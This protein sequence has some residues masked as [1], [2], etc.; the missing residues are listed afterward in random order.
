MRDGRASA[1]GCL[2]RATRPEFVEDYRAALVALGIIRDPRACA[3]AAK[4]ETPA[5]PLDRDFPPNTFGW[6]VRRYLA[7]S[8]EY[9]GMKPNGR[10]RRRTVL[11]AMLPTIGHKPMIIPRA[12]IS[13]G[14]T[15]RAEKPG[16]ANNWLKCVKALYTWA[17]KVAIITESPAK[18]LGK[19]DQHDKGFH[20]WSLAEIKGYIQRHPRGSMAYLALI[21]LLFTGLRRSDAITLGRQHVRDGVIQFRTSKTGSE[22]VTDL[23]WPLDEAMRGMPQGDELAILQNAFGKHF[24]SGAAFGNWFRDRCQEAKLPHCT[25][26]GLR[27]AGA[28]IA[29]EN[30]ASEV[31]LDAMYGWSNQRQSGT[32]TKAARNRVL[33]TAGFNRIADTLV[34]AGVLEQKTPKIVAP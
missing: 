18:G 32:Y 31:E 29:A 5:T 2:I 27:K 30:G 10:T 26:H 7:E 12:K 34:D 16:S 1:C 28:T 9:R 14:L 4:P 24:A 15:A 17:A 19:L 25:A 3:A 22:L 8:P 23:P 20:T 6:L 33:A 13:E 11:E 21:L